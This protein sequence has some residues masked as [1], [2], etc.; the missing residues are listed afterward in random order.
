M[1][2]TMLVLV[3]L[4][5]LVSASKAQETDWYIKGV[6][7]NVLTDWAVLGKCAMYE[8]NLEEDP[9][10]FSYYND[11]VFNKYKTPVM[12]S[13]LTIGFSNSFIIK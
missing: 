3:L 5:Q 2:K 1:K 10:T 13:Y 7:V 11:T 4:V 9:V 12:P 6:S 8:V